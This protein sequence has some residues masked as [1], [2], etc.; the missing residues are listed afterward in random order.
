MTLTIRLL[1]PVQIEQNGSP[2]EMRGHKPLALLAYLLLTDQAHSR[3]HLVDLFFDNSNDPRASLRWTLSELKRAIGADHIQADRQQ[4]GF[5]FESD[6]WLDVSDFEQDQ[7]DLYRGDFL[8]GL[9]VRDAFGFEEWAF[10]ER[11]RLRK[12]YQTALVKQLEASEQGEDTQAVIETAHLLLRLDN[13]REAW[14]RALMYAYARQGQREAALAQFERCQQILQSELGVAPD[15]ETVDLATAIREGVIGETKRLQPSQPIRPPGPL[16]NLPAQAT[17]FV[18]R[19]EELCWITNHLANPDCRLLTLVGPGGIGKTR[20]A[21]QAAAEVIPTKAFSQG[22]YFVALA[23]VSSPEFIVPAIADALNFSFFGRE[24]PKIQLLNYF[25]DKKILLILDNF[26]HLLAGVDLVTDIMGQGCNLKLLVSSRERLNLRGEWLLDVHGLQ[27]P[28]ASHGETSPTESYSAVQLFLQSA[29]RLDAAFTLSPTNEPYVVRICQLVEGMALGVELAASWIRTLTCQQI[30]R[31]IEQS[32]DF[33]STSVRDVPARHRSLKAV[34]DHS[35]KLLSDEE[36]KVYRRMAVFRGEFCRAAA[37]Q[38]TNTSLPILSTLVDKSFLRRTPQGRYEV[39]ELLRQFAAKKLG[40]IPQEKDTVQDSHCHYYTAFLQQREEALIGP[41]QKEALA[42]IRSEIENVRAAWRWATE[43]E[44]LAEIERS[45]TALFRFYERQSLFQEGA[46]VF[47]GAITQLERSGH[48]EKGTT[49]KQ[50]LIMGRLLACR[51]G[52]LDRFGEYE[53]AR[54]LLQKSL[55]LIGRVQPDATQEAAFTFMYLGTAAFDQGDYSEARQCLDESVS[56]CRRFGNRYGLA[57]SLMVLDN[58][59]Y[60]RGD[61]AEAKQL[62]RESLVIFNELG[63]QWGIGFAYCDLGLVAYLLGEYVEAKQSLQESIAVFK[64]NENLWGLSFSYNNLG[65]VLGALGAYEESKQLQEEA[66][67]IVQEIGDQDGVAFCLNKLGVVARCR[68]AYPEA[69]QLGTESLA[70][71]KEMRGR[72]GI[73]SALSNL[74]RIAYLQGEYTEAADLLQESLTIRREIGYHRGVGESLA[75]LGQLNVAQDEPQKGKKFLLE[76]LQTALD[77][78]ARAIALD[79]LT[80]LAE[81]LIKEEESEQAAELL[82]LVRHHPASEQETKDRAK[83][84]LTTMQ[85]H[86]GE[87][88]KTLAEVAAQM[89]EQLSNSDG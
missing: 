72:R 40:E 80:G 81:L 34:F 59:A 77:I 8:E 75:Y 44:I 66:L 83:D 69:K 11:E 35:W 67:T 71:F 18:G 54:Q 37:E 65:R 19:E 57:H 64:V 73:A 22:V 1:G 21:I 17:P 58:V 32:L 29:A 60:A 25:R 51:G 38:V 84:I 82:A 26:E 74:G 86:V 4:I 78:Q 56:I 33:L 89:L 9:Q 23:P 31:E 5:N 70:L 45:I 6:Y 20:L 14:Y 13:L 63:D 49:T 42:E 62:A 3:Q 15:I 39:H 76:A 85:V 27:F 24:E 88:E 87:S 55:A 52:L 12:S 2:I 48:I 16:H 28:A 46:S 41:D 61:Y 7:T 43:R 50:T 79:V 36:R 47:Q 68:G 10:F 53:Y 30:A